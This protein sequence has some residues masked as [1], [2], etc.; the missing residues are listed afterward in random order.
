MEGKEY[1]RFT[2][3]MKIFFSC[4]DLY[5]FI[6]CLCALCALLKYFEDIQ[7]III[8]IPPILNSIGKHHLNVVSLDQS[9]CFSVLLRS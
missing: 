4:L 8:Q 3:Y 5:K 1:V 6:M 7:K 2:K 9:L